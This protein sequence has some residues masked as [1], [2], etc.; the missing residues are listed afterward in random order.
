MIDYQVH[1]FHHYLKRG[2]VWF[3]NPFIP[4]APF[5]YPL[6]TSETLK[7]FQG[8]DKGSLE[9]NGLIIKTFHS[10]PAFNFRSRWNFRKMLMIIIES[11]MIMKA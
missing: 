7:C 2:Q 6:K 1:S 11:R 8:V 10:I 4:S 9:T 3:S 5:L